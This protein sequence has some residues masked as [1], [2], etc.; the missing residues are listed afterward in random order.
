[1][2]LCF[3]LPRCDVPS[4]TSQNPEP[5]WQQRLEAVTGRGGKSDAG[6]VQSIT[7]SRS[8]YRPKYRF[9]GEQLQHRERVGGSSNKKALPARRERGDQ[10][11]RVWSIRIATRS[12][13]QG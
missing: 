13:C 5:L 1:M 12:Q 9:H 7:L 6:E 10:A 4:L 3:N 2:Y 8:G 11:Q